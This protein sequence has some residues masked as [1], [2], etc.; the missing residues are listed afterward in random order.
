M[1]G[2]IADDL[3]GAA[4]I[5]AVGLRHGLSA[6]IVLAGATMPVAAVSPAAKVDLLCLDTDSRL[7]PAEES[8]RRA[9]GAAAWLKTAGARW[10][11]KKVD[12]VLRGQVTAELEAVIAAARCPLVLLVPANP[13][14]G[15]VIRGGRYYVRGKPLDETEFSYDAM[16]PRTSAFVLE[17]ISPARKQPVRVCDRDDALPTAGIV[18]GEAESIEHLDHW[19]QAGGSQVLRAGGAEFFAA[20]LRAEGCKPVVAKSAPLARARMARELFVCGS[21]STAAREFHASSLAAGIPVIGLPEGVGAA[22]ALTGPEHEELVRRAVSAF[23]SKARVVL[24]V[25]LERVADPARAARLSSCVVQVAQGV[26]GKVAVDRVFAEGGATAVELARTLGWGRLKVLRE[27]SPGVASLGLKG[28]LPAE[29]TIK[30]GSYLWP[31]D[32]ATTKEYS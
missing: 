30:P 22:G 24:R 3:T 5:G 15:R 6:E 31:P 1:I 16:H 25:G 28:R 21:N 32:V 23:E 8:A 4:E 13:S 26:L 7:C 20:V 18:I 10:I 9:Q 29:L 17:M 14:L 11:Y 12:S 2:V 27:L 19:A